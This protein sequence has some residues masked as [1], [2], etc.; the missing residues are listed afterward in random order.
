MS[1]APGTTRS[2]IETAWPA[3]ASERT[4]GFWQ[5]LAVMTVTAIATWV[6][7]IGGVVAGYLPAYAGIAAFV[8]STLIA[9]ALVVLATIP[10]SS[11]YG[12]DS[13]ISTRPQLGTRGSW[14]ALAMLI[15]N[16]IGW[17]AVLIILLGR[18]SAQ[19]LISSG[20]LSEGDRHITQTLSIVGALIIVWVL[21]RRG[22]RAIR[23]VA[24]FIAIGVVLLAAWIFY[25]LLI[26]VG[27]SEILAGKPQFG[28]TNSLHDYMVGFDI[29][30]APQLGF[31]PYIGALVRFVPGPRRAVWP[32]MIGLVLPVCF[33]GL[34][35]L[36]AEL[37]IPGSGG[38]PTAYLSELSGVA[39]AAPALAFVVLGNIGTTAVGIY[40]SAVALKQV[41]GIA[42]RVPWDAT[43]ATALAPVLIVGIF[44][45]DQF[46]ANVGFFLVFVGVIFAPLC[47]IQIVD[48]FI[49]RKQRIDVESLVTSEQTGSYRF[50]GGVNPI[51]VLALVV[52]FVVYIWLL[53]PLT[54]EVA[55]IHKFVSAG[56]PAA[57]I[58]GLVYW[59]LTHMLVARTGRGGYLSP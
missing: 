42:E 17:N 55:P 22:Q 13:V 41:P 18:A 23:V 20:I 46:F 56:V 9:T 24:P 2:G 39:A 54:L 8:S 16:V 27:W 7:P 26:H 51:G 43:T 37:S 5:L 21:L 10:I 45:R 3:R 19:V 49:L 53:N 44:F 40:V 50:W 28:G 14:I 59:L 36:F 6:F 31:W 47:A 15:I 57:V 35:G 38:D 29:E 58:A 11:S 1:K 30:F 12:V 33:I 48:Y 25:L 52:G 4:W 34:I 32:A